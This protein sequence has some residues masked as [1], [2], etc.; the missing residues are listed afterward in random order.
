MVNLITMR[1]QEFFN[2]NFDRCRIWATV[3]ILLITPKV[4]D[5]LFMKLYEGVGCLTSNKV[6]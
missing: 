4:V 3:Q 1:I 5:E 6:A 2:R